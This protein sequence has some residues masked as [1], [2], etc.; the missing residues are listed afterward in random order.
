MLALVKKKIIFC[1]S[2]VVYTI[3][4]CCLAS[5]LF[6]SSEIHQ[7]REKLRIFVFMSRDIKSRKIAINVTSRIASPPNSKIAY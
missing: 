3:V 1:I 5:E 4:R 2:T 6:L 7:K